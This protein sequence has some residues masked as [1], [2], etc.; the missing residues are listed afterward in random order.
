MTH[1]ARLLLV[2]FLALGSC[3]PRQLDSN[4][5]IDQQV[6]YCANTRAGGLVIGNPQA[7]S[8]VPLIGQAANATA[9]ILQEEEACKVVRGLRPDDVSQLK[10]AQAMAAR[11]NRALTSGSFTITPRPIG[12][13]C[14]PLTTLHRPSGQALR[15][16]TL[17]RDKQGNYAPLGQR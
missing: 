6:V 5:A 13:D 3:A 11:E 16:E 9:G 15:Q 4:W 1:R 17:C 2:T 12:A 8:G 10:I 14:V 7:F